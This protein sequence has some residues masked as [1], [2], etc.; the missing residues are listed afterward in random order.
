MGRGADASQSRYV[1]WGRAFA[2]STRSVSLAGF[3][4]ERP[5]FSIVDAR[6]HTIKFAHAHQQALMRDLIN[7]LVTVIHPFMCFRFRHGIILHIQIDVVKP[8]PEIIF[9]PLLL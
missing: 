9:Y 3:Q 6:E 4:T 5:K 8:P 7:D 1:E 2:T